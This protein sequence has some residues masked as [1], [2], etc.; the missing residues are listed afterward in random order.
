MKEDEHETIFELRTDKVRY[1]C[2]GVVGTYPN[3]KQV[4]PGDRKDFNKTLTFSDTDLV[5]FD[6]LAPHIKGN[7]HNQMFLRGNGDRVAAGIES[8]DS[9]PCAMALPGCTYEGRGAADITINCKFLQDALK[10]G[11]CNMQVRDRFTP[12]YFNREDGGLHLIMPLRSEPSDALSKEFD[13]IV[14]E[15]PDAE[16]ENEPPPE[17]GVESSPEEAETTKPEAEKENENMP[18][19]E[20]QKQKPQ[21]NSSLKVVETEDPVARLEELAKES[22]EAVKAA[23]TFVKEL[24]KQVRTVKSYYRDRDKDLKSRE[25]EMSKNLELINKLQESIAA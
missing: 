24:K 13:A 5:T 18:N 11:F 19:T 6:A 9:G 10:N 15:V 1:V 17:S 14:G 21:Q 4:I 2:K 16:P 25:K 12:L 20:Q 8:E 22:R 3:Y 7:S 23:E